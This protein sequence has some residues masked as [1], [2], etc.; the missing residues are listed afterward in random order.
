MP[1]R[2]RSNATERMGVNFVRDIVE[3]HNCVFKDV[4]HEQDYGHDAFV[5]LVEGETVLPVEVALQIKSGSS[6]SKG[7]NCRIPASAAHF[8]F[9]RSHPLV[10][11]GIVYDPLEACGYWTNLTE[12]VK[13]FSRN[14][15]PPSAIMFP[16]AKWNR[17]D[18]DTFSSLF[19]QAMLKRLPKLSFEEAQGWAITEDYSEHDLGIR[20]LLRDYINDARTWE[21]FFD[22]FAQREPQVITPYLIYAL[23]HIPWHGDIAA[24][25]FDLKIR[26]ALQERWSVLGADVI[27][28]LLYFVD[29]NGFERGSVGQNAAALIFAIEGYEATLKKL[30]AEKEL[31]NLQRWAVQVL[32]HERHH[33]PA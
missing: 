10:T 2:K 20:V 31:E 26:P 14:E 23:A 32:L 18:C 29:E 25:G 13:S 5:L 1:I 9:W 6:Y 27:S 15:A 21:I 19:F 7:A 22:A 12:T 11:F 28:K 8:D 4:H 33:I 17:F 24:F 3:R 16:K 30:A